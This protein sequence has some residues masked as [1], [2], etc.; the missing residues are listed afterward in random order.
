[1]SLI[2][3]RT[4]DHIVTC[5]IKLSINFFFDKLHLLCSSNVI[6]LYSLIDKLNLHSTK[7]MNIED[8]NWC[9]LHYHFSYIACY[10]IFLSQYFIMFTLENKMNNR[11]QQKWE[12][13]SQ[14]NQCSTFHINHFHAIFYHLSLN[15]ASIS[16]D[17]M[18]LSK[19]ILRSIKWNIYLIVTI[20][21]AINE[22]W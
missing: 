4:P 14:F 21:I 8:R 12:H 13:L 3:W 19:A 22:Y 17:E 1:M 6:N 2:Q 5:T 9:Y 18:K 11:W 16:D 15:V 7:Q 20:I 10:D